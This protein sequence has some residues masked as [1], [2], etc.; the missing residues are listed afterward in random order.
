METFLC[1]IIFTKNMINKNKK[2]NFTKDTLL[3]IAGVGIITL[4]ATSSPY[5]LHKLVK[6]YF[7][8]KTEADIRRRSKKL[9]EFNKKKLVNFKELEDGTIKI[10]L[11]QAG[12]N[13]VHQYKLDDMKIPKP[14]K[15]DG[16]WRIVIYD[17]PQK[18]KKVSDAFRGK[19]KQ[20]GMYQLQ[21]SIWVYPYECINELDFLCS[22]FGL[23]LEKCVLYFKADKLP[24]NNKIKEFFNLK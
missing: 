10:E 3:K 1:D 18:F 9:A 11:T 14:A 4:A 12:K 21:K 23:P 2:I 17:I 19:I 15:W 6:N 7:K 5:F 22:V 24:N 13:I 16:Q 20:L 8:D